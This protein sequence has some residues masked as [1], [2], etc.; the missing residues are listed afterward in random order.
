MN[1]SRT[2]GAMSI[3]TT[4]TGSP[5]QTYL[6]TPSTV[7]LREPPMLAQQT[8]PKTPFGPTTTDSYTINARLPTAIALVPYLAFQPC[9][10]V[11]SAVPSL[12]RSTQP[13]A[14]VSGLNRCYATRMPST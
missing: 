7:P 2:T 3:E 5:T 12:A 13:A 8:H 14:T 4:P 6:T 11:H 9:Y 1:M 10:A